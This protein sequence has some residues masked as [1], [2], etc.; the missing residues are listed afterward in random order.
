MIPPEEL[1]VK[2][3][4]YLE[5]ESFRDPA[6][7]QRLLELSEDP[8][9]EN[10]PGNAKVFYESLNKA[11][12][13]FE[14]NLKTDQKS[15]GILQAVLLKLFWN[16]LMSESEKNIQAAVNANTLISL[17][18]GI[19][20]KFK[21]Q[22]W[23]SVYEFNF[24][25]DEETRRNL[26]Y[27]LE[28]NNEQLGSRGIYLDG[29]Q[30]SP[31]VSAWLR[32]YNSLQPAKNE[33]GRF[34]Q[35]AYFNGSK[36]VNI[37]TVWEKNLL[38][39]LLELYDWILYPPAGIV[40]EREQRTSEYTNQVSARTTPPVLSPPVPP[41]PPSIKQSPVAEDVLPKTS[42]LPP[43]PQSKLPQVSY[44]QPSVA[45]IGLKLNATGQQ[46]SASEESKSKVDI[47]KTIDRKL[48]DLR[49]KIN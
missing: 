39:G 7:L 38:G 1:E 41:R 3:L 19:D 11:I 31:T 5:E 49:K 40:V 30:V 26:A 43:S 6:V 32:D 9:Y 21:I 25:P 36:N 4:K 47:S 24:V 14:Q 10:E 28:T 29:K 37:L 2:Y 20:V 18:L 48:E 44:T 22:R 23:L 42:S 16:S 46:K 17:K 13:P 33:R 34:E 35:I 27:A 12:D 45:D 8:Q 15:Y